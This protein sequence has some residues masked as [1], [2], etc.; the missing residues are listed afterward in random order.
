[1][2]SHYIAYL[3]CVEQSL[4]KLFSLCQY[5]MSR[6]H[7]LTYMAYCLCSSLFCVLMLPFFFF[8]C[9]Q[10]EVTQRLGNKAAPGRAAG[11]QSH[12]DLARKL[13]VMEQ[14]CELSSVVSFV[15]TRF[16]YFKVTLFSCIVISN[17]VGAFVHVSQRDSIIGSCSLPNYLGLKVH[18]VCL[19]LGLYSDFKRSLKHKVWLALSSNALLVIIFMPGPRARTI[20]LKTL[21]K[22]SIN[23][24][25]KKVE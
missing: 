22:N 4:F 24:A 12:E 2:F 25:H 20:E 9:L 16:I 19:C 1:M 15:S 8:F 17:F 14:V 10:A 7:K 3:L 13:Q 6:L 23:T 18:F 11:L 21:M 5:V